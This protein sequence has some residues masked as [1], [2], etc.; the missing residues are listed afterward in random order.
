MESYKCAHNE[1]PSQ[2]ICT[3]T[4]L[5][6]NSYLTKIDPN[7]NLRSACKLTLSKQKVHIPIDAAWQ[8]KIDGTRIIALQSL[9]AAIYQNPKPDMWVIDLGLTS[10]VTGYPETFNLGIH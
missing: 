6:Q 1:M 3:T 7:L 8:G 9:L 10:E 4:S 5:V 2:K